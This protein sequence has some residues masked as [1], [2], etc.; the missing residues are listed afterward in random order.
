L[1]ICRK[2][3][4]VTGDGVN[5]APALKQADIGVA[6]GSGSAVAREAA[7]IIL[8]DSKFSSVTVGILYGR[9]V[10]D[11]LKKVNS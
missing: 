1:R 4:A 11:N 8:M 6:I 7:D 2:I 10:F 9:L 3:V 5:D